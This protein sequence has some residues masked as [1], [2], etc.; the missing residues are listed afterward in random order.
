VAPTPG[1]VGNCGLSWH[2][3][4]AVSGFD[5]VPARPS[6]PAAEVP[7]S[8]SRQGSTLHSNKV[9]IQH[10]ISDCH[11]HIRRLLQCTRVSR[12]PAL[13]RATSEQLAGE[14]NRDNLDQ[15][16][17]AAYRSDPAPHPII[18]RDR[19][20]RD[21]AGITPPGFHEVVIRLAPDHTAH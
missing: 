2:P 11:Q 18:H 17:R 1:S 13:G 20:E 21:S 8:S 15:S 16:D 14:T 9:D 7:R 5:E 3:L 10:F 19:D 6:L 12:S 4:C